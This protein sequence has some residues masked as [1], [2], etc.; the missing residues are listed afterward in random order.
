MHSLFAERAMQRFVIIA[1]PLFIFSIALGT[2]AAEVKK[3]SLTKLTTQVGETFW[4]APEKRLVRATVYKKGKGDSDSKNGKSDEKIGLRYA[5]N[6][7]AGTLAIP[8]WLPRGSMV[9]IHT[10]HGVLSYIAA[11]EGSDIET[12]EAAR[13]GGKTEEQ[14]AAPVLDF[15]AAEQLWPDFVIV[16]IYYYAGKVAFSDLSSENQKTLFAYAMEYVT[17]RE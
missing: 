14:K 13:D 6:Q 4:S 17:K 1:L 9:K 11:D 15:C 16:E 10:E 5:T 7:E 12:R 8:Q 3:E 2:V